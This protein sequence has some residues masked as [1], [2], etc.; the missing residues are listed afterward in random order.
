MKTIRL[1]Q[2]DNSDNVLL[3]YDYELNSKFK[4]SKLLENIINDDNNINNI[5][6]IPF[7]MEY[8]ESNIKYSKI[9]NMKNQNSTVKV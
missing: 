8:P 6:N 9:Y 5:N 7:L 1:H 2:N 3:Q 4:F